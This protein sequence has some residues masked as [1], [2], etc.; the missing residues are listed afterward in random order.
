M[1]Y[2][3]KLFIIDTIHITSDCRMKD[4]WKTGNNLKESARDLLEVLAFA[5]SN[6]GILR[7]TSV[8]IAWPNRGIIPEGWRKTMKSSI[9]IACVLAKIRTENLPDT[10][11]PKI[12]W[13]IYFIDFFL[14]TTRILSEILLRIVNEMKVNLV[15]IYTPLAFKKEII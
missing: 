13:A 6:W 12:Y 9:R 14:L 15:N 3:T 8:R 11:V 10:G 7:N 1:G 2:F 4:E 5:L